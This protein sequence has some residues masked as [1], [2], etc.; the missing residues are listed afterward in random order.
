[1]RKTKTNKPSQF[2]AIEGLDGSGKSTQ[3][4]LLINYLSSKGFQTKFVHFPRSHEG[5]F[6]ELIS[7]FLRGEFGNIQDV[8]PQ[9]TALLFAEDRKEFS[10]T[11]IEWLNDGY[12]V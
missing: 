11:I 5:I 3:I 4:E 9:L 1:M 8:H 10:P 2:I 6:G 7:K 12:F